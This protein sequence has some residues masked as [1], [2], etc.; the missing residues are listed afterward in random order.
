MHHK[1]MLEAYWSENIGFNANNMSMKNLK[2]KY[3]ILDLKIDYA[4]GTT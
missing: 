1:F 2:R 3:V 4:K